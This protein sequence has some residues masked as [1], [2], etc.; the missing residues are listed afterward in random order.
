MDLAEFLILKNNSLLPSFPD[1]YTSLLLF[2][3]LPVS[4]AKAERSFSK[5]KLIKTYLRNSIAQERLSG[6][7]VISIE[8]QEAR[9]VDTDKIVDGF[10]RLK[11]RK[12]KM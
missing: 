11:A 8:N 3:T 6:L 5:L 1:I 10:A 7:A 2:L 9:L 4:V 12:K